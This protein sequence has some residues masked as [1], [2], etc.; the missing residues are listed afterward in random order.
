M[1]KSEM[2]RAIT[3]MLEAFK[4]WPNKKEVAEGI[5]KFQ[6]SIGMLPP[7]QDPSI[8]EDTY[9]GGTKHGPAQRAWDEE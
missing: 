6:E 4:D 5:L 3:T 8:V 7:V 2:I 9:H 1:K